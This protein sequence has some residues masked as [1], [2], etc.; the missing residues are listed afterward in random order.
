[1]VTL[2]LQSKKTPLCEHGV[3]DILLVLHC[4]SIAGHSCQ[5]VSA[6]RS[7]YNYNYMVLTTKNDN[8]YLILG[9]TL[10]ER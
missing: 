3:T 10:H 5:L 4:A 2:N 6:E 8:R 9:A 1:M 7:L